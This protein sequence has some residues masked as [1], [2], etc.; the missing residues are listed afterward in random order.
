MYL[1]GRGV[2]KNEARA[3]AYYKAAADQLYPKAFRCLGNY[4][5]LYSSQAPDYR[6]ALDA[7]VKGALCGEQNSLY[8]LGDM[9]QGGEHVEKDDHFAFQL[10]KTAETAIE[11]NDFGHPDN[12]VT[13][14]DCYSDVQLRLGECFLDGIGTDADIDRAIECLQESVRIFK[15]RIGDGDDPR[16]F[17]T[18]YMLRAQQGLTEAL[19]RHDEATGLA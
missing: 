4:W 9:Y 15:R 19:R 10:Y 5:Y 11:R 8:M 6:L 18:R 1:D 13:W 16:G 17:N 2:E 12:D 3:L 14:D 7:F